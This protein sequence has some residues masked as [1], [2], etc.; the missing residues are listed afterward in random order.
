MVLKRL[1]N[2]NIHTLDE[3]SAHQWESMAADAVAGIQAEAL[4]LKPLWRNPDIVGS[5]D[6]FKVKKSQPNFPEQ[7]SGVPLAPSN[8]SGERYCVKFQIG[9]CIKEGPCQLRLHRCAAVFRSGRTCHRNHPFST[10]WDTR[11]HALPPE[12]DPVKPVQSQAKDED[13]GYRG[14]RA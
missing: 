7:L 9:S 6:G 1:A 2:D 11:R 8:R 5:K 3:I 4:E 13:P 12:V 10:C 14:R